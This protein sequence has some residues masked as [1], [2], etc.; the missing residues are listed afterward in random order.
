MIQNSVVRFNRIFNQ[1]HDKIDFKDLAAIQQ[2]IS[3]YMKPNKGPQSADSRRTR[4]TVHHPA[5]QQPLKQK[6][7][8]KKHASTNQSRIDGGQASPVFRIEELPKNPDID[9]EIQSPA[10]RQPNNLFA[11]VNKTIGRLSQGIRVDN[12]EPIMD[13]RLLL[14]I[15]DPKKT[16]KYELNRKYRLNRKLDGNNKVWH[17]LQMEDFDPVYRSKDFLQV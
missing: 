4:R 3:K 15:I 7:S 1:V 11:N 14:A 12:F 8:P 2:L 10:V 13:L 6:V 17:S 9:S 16:N 5:Q